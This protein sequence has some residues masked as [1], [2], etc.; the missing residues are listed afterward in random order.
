MI[1][2]ILADAPAQM[3]QTVG[4]VAFFGGIVLFFVVMKYFAWRISK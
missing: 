3:S 2:N 1:L 4:Y